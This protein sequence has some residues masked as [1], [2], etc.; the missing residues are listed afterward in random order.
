MYSIEYT[1]RFK[2]DLKLCQKRGLDMSLIF[3]AIKILTEN[4]SLPEEY[5]ENTLANG[6]AIYNQIGSWFGNNS[7]MNCE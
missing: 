6:N 3:N 5:K 1:N 2:K 7:T 4:G